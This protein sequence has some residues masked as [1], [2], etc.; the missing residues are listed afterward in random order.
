MRRGFEL[1]GLRSLIVGFLR[2]IVGFL[3]TPY[4]GIRVRRNPSINIR[5]ATV[6]G[7][8]IHGQVR[9]LATPLVRP[10]FFPQ[11]PI[12]IANFN[13][14]Q[15]L[16]KKYLD[17]LVI[18]LKKSSLP[19]NTFRPLSLSVGKA[20]MNAERYEFRQCRLE[21]LNVH[22]LTMGE[23]IVRRIIHSEESSSHPSSLGAEREGAQLDAASALAATMAKFSQGSTAQATAT[24]SV[25]S[26][27][28]DVRPG[29]LSA[30]H[31]RPEP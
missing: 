30:N 2:I 5:Q 31:S 10:S 16:V 21:A 20:L 24:T 17:L 4:G 7:E 12:I 27:S 22:S 13:N 8:K 1:C 28:A 26:K 19:L 6:V 14:T 11:S 29:S 9:Y 23:T 3:R 18:I 25:R 15:E